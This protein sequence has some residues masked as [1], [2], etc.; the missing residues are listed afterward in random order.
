MHQFVHWKSAIQGAVTVAEVHEVMEQ[1]SVSI[2]AG[3]K[4]TL[5]TPCKAV[6]RDVD[7]AGGAVT[8]MREEAKFQ[9]D[10]ETASLLHEIAQ[11]FVA[12]ADR[13]AFLEGQTYPRDAASR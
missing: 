13:I 6:L 9:G 2:A 7:I 12:A 5:P 4:V 3:D 8:F 10:A 11:T 1:Y